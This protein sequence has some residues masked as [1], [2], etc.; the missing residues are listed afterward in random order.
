[1][2]TDFD[3]GVAV[4]AGE[5]SREAEQINRKGAVGLEP[6][7]HRLGGHIQA[8][9]GHALGGEGAAQRYAGLLGKLVEVGAALARVKSNRLNLMLTVP[10]PVNRDAQG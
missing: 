2:F 6:G 1:V 10:R 7:Q 5:L 3:P 4:E 8:R 9:L